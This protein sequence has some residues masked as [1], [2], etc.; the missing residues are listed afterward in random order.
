MSLV[1]DQIV[2]IDEQLDRLQISAPS[3]D[4]PSVKLTQAETHDPRTAPR[5]AKLRNT[6]KALS[7]ASSSRAV[8][9]PPHRIA[10]I[11]RDSQLSRPS[12][13][14]Q[15]EGQTQGE[16]DEEQDLEI[17]SSEYTQELEWLLVSK[18]T[19]QTY[20]ALLEALLSAT[21]PLSE[22]IS[23]WNIV[24]SSYRWSAIY[25]I[26]TSPLR[27]WT[28]AGDI[29]HDVKARI[30]VEQLGHG[31][32]QEWRQFY[33]LVGEVVQERNLM[34]L[35]ERL[36]GPIV[37]VREEV[38][39]KKEALGRVRG[40][41]ANAVGMLLGEGL[42]SIHDDVL[43][44]PEISTTH[45]HRERWKST[46]TR[47]IALMEAVLQHVS[48]EEQTVDKFDTAINT[49]I[50]DDPYYEPQGADL[51]GRD[52]IKPSQL[53]S[54]LERVLSLRLD[55]YAMHNQNVVKRHGRPPRL[56][57]YWLLGSIALIS[58]S[59]ILRILFNRKAEILTWIR[60]FGA[61][62]IDF[63]TNWV[64]EPTKK[65]IGTIRHD[66]SSEVSLMSKRSLEGDL[67]SLERMV[68]DFTIA[69]AEGTSLGEAEIQDLRV[70]IRE[71]DLTPVLKVYEKDLERP[72][73]GALR[74]D[75]VR[76][77]L[78]QIQKMKVDVEI[79]VGGIDQMLKSQELVF[80][81]IGLTPGVLVC[82]GV[83]RWLSGLFSERKGL[84]QGK[85][86]MLRGLRNINRILI[87]AKPTQDYGELF[88][89]DHGLL[90]CEV[91]ALRQSAK[92]VLPSN[93]F[94]DFVEDIADLVDVRT[95][96]ERQRQAVKHLRWIYLN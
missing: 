7:T 49:T 32:T 31:L 6:V 14:R 58:S 47:N 72:F 83:F 93:V 80:G 84:Q 56:V 35:R 17:G 46:I 40:L 23:Y 41:N 12:E 37:R 81:F 33:S 68:V 69:N 96:V 55:N 77:A 39:G 16:Q 70:K 71:G 67:A 65:V 26:Q 52:S 66:E 76:A 82:F 85:K 50:N 73:V 43:I 25:S 86:Q 36:A 74:G 5:I 59:T 53:A 63:W 62:V 21:V 9:L 87:A 34:R 92:R 1:I 44:S 54:R 61:T 95:G 51:E 2:R 90:L 64:V 94:R 15:I 28:W 45:Q 4:E 11:L 75:L 29:Y 22:D 78:I 27:L 89:K 3:D 24:L 60:E 57:R 10:A 8:I 18:A 19:V 13:R 20:G 91:Q 48:D 88:Y 42:S 30:G 79:L 38:R